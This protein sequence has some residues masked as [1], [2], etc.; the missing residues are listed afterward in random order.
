M[1][2]TNKS[3]LAGQ[4]NIKKHLTNISYYDIIITEREQRNRGK[5][6]RMKIIKLKNEIDAVGMVIA[7]SHAPIKDK[8]LAVEALFEMEKGRKKKNER[9][10]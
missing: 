4:K 8:L 10:D 2:T 9:I 3:S 6:N 1:R 7:R 5:E